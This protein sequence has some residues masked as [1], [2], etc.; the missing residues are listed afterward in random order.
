MLDWH[1]K[2]GIIV[3]SWN[4]VME[5]EFGQMAQPNSSVHAQRIK[6][7]DDSEKSLLWLSTQASAAAELLSHAKVHAICHGCTASGFLKTPEDDLNQAKELSEQTQI[8]CVTSASSIV[9]ALRAVSG[10]K[11]SVASPYEPWLNERVKIYLELAGFEV[12]AIA[13]LSTQ[14]HGSISAPIIKSLAREVL[15]SNTEALFISCS[16]FRTLHL[17]TELEKELGVPVITSNQASMWGALRS[18]NDLRSI[19]NAGQLF[20][21]PSTLESIC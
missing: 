1:T 21:N 6:H 12:L 7:T 15:R 8:P 5:F 20:Q 2:L 13:G 17:I 16:N 4:T 19:P 3:P 14:D 9:G 10:R 11:I 18:M